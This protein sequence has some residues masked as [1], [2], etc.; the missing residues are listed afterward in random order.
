M[1]LGGE[2]WEVVRRAYYLERKSQ[3]QVAKGGGRSRETIKAV[4]QEAEG[5]TG[6]T[7]R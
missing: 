3:R 7:Q 4:L 2:E 1:S 5:E 6:R